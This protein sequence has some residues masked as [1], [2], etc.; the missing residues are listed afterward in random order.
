MV[1]SFKV[2]IEENEDKVSLVTSENEHT[3]ILHKIVVPKHLRN[4]GHGNKKM[5]ELTDYAD[6]KGKKIALTPSTHFGGSS[7]S[8]LKK[9]YKGHGFIENKGKSRDF[10]TTETMIRHPKSFSN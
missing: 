4:Q 10:Q 9:F 2:F 8:R 7:V 1:K 5:K 3:I 6:S